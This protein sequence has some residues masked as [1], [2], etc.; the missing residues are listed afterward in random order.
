MTV[1]FV[2]MA[3][4]KRERHCYYTW[5]S[6]AGS[7]G[8]A[9]NVATPGQGRMMDTVHIGFIPQRNLER[10]LVNKRA[11]DVDALLNKLTIW[12]CALACEEVLLL[13]FS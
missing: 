13:L 9:D 4:D 3:A 7:D 12:V 11:N 8:K 2:D 1:S 10:C 5:A 6:A